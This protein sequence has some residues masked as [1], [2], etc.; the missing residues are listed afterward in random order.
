MMWPLS[1]FDCFVEIWATCENFWANGSAPHPRAKSCPYAYALWVVVL[2]N[3]L[4]SFFLWNIGIEWENIECSDDC[5]VWKWC[6]FNEMNKVS[7]VFNVC[8]VFSRATDSRF[9]SVFLRKCPSRAMSNTADT[10]W[11]LTVYSGN[12]VSLFVFTWINLKEFSLMVGMG[13]SVAGASDSVMSNTLKPLTNA[14]TV[15]GRPTPND[16]NERAFSRKGS[17]CELVGSRD[18]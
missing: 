4:D 5:V 11:R 18:L 15:R 7:C 14:Q 16:D 2:V 17:F 3:N 12:G 1:L 13:K 6:V 8:L 9:T 10:Q